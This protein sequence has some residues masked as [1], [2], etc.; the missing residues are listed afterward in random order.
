MT[1]PTIVPIPPTKK[2]PAARKKKRRPTFRPARQRKSLAAKDTPVV[3]APNN[4]APAAS[5]EAIVTPV[6]PPEIENDEQ[7]QRQSQEDDN[8]EVESAV[9]TAPAKR[10]RRK[11]VVAIGSSRRDEAVVEGA[12]HPNEPVSLA[13]PQVP[14]AAPGQPALKTFCSR[15]RNKEKRKVTQKT[16]KAPSQQEQNGALDEQ[17]T[18]NTGPV[19]QVVNGEIVL[20]ESSVVLPGAR[21]SVQEVEEEFEQVVEEEAQ[22]SAVVG[23][24]Y[25]SFVSRRAPQHWSVAET[26]KF[27]DALRQVGADFTTMTTYFDNRT[28]KQLKR[29]YQIESTKN[30]HLIELALSPQAQIPLGEYMG[31]F[32]MKTGCCCTCVADSSCWCLIICRLVCVQHASRWFESR[33]KQHNDWC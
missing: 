1:S 13:E 8:L 26:K 28:R 12:A 9:R 4:S 23:A 21:R 30:P 11:Q 6:P 24:S 25:N 18:E 14:V 15:Y 3:I 32:V 16:T 20:Q 27:Y 5:S 10:K 19:V 33:C 31:K 7:T 17:S 22:H 2:A 29:K